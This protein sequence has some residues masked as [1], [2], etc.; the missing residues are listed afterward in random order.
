MLQPVAKEEFFSYDFE[1]NGFSACKDTTKIWNIQIIRTFFTKC[2][3]N[4]TKK[5][6]HNV[7]SSLF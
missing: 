1:F 4:S 7:K 6:L 2:S 3:Q 5:A